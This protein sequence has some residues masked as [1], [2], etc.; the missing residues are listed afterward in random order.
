MHATLPKYPHMQVLL[1][2]I[3]IVVVFLLL[4]LSMGGLRSWADAFRSERKRPDNRFVQMWWPPKP[5]S[6]LILLGAILYIYDCLS[7]PPFGS[8]RLSVF[9]SRVPQVSRFSRPGR[10]GWQADPRLRIRVGQPPPYKT[11]ICQNQADVGHRL[12]RTP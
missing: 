7:H 8:S 6:Y 10:K 5:S 3:W 1:F 2:V 4:T 9:L 12:L 11:H